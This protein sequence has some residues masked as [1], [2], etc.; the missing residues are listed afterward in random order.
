M[1]DD[2][3]EALSEFIHSEM[4]E[5]WAKEIIKSEPCISQERQERWQ[6]CF[7][8]YQELTEEMKE[9]DRGFARRIITL[10]ETF[11]NGY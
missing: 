7:V 4:W 10:M 3:L 1:E 5:K 11:E 8:P 9:L 6:G 2:R